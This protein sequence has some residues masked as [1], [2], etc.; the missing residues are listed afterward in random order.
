MTESSVRV[1]GSW[2]ILALVL[3]ILFTT[4]VG[5]SIFGSLKCIVTKEKRD[6]AMRLAIITASI[7][8]LVLLVVG[9]WIIV[10]GNMPR[11]ML[12]ATGFLSLVCLSL[13]GMSVAVATTAR[14]RNKTA[15]TLAGTMAAIASVTLIFVFIIMMVQAFAREKE[16]ITELRPEI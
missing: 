5:W 11:T 4:M 2:A 7:G 9:I 10:R 3:F 8:A 6:R 15:R 16:R 12:L 14:K 13:V 1:V